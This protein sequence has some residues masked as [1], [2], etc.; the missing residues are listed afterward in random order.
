MNEQEKQDLRQWA[1]DVALR[2]LSGENTGRYLSQDSTLIYKTAGK[3]LDF[4]D[5]TWNKRESVEQALR[6][7]E[8]ESGDIGGIKIDD[9]IKEATQFYSFISGD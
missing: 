4:V 7:L 9:I 2:T 6:V 8:P 3:L 5:Y 1:L